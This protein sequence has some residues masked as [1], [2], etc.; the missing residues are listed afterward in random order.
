MEQELLFALL[1]Q[2][3]PYGRATPSGLHIP[4]KKV[5]SYSRLIAGYMA[6]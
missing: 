3:M 6:K 2:S 5:I 4:G 1:R